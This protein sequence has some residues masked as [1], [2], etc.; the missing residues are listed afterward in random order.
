MFSTFPNL[1]FVIEEVN[2][3]VLN[4]SKQSPTR[5]GLKPRDSI[6]ITEE[7][8]VP[9][10][11]NSQ[12]RLEA[13]KPH[14]PP[15]SSGC[16]RCK[17]LHRMGHA[18]R[19]HRGSSGPQTCPSGVT[20]EHKAQ[21]CVQM[22]LGYLQWETFGCKEL[23]PHALHWWPAQNLIQLL[24]QAA[25]G[26]YLPPVSIFSGAEVVKELG[27]FPLFTCLAWTCL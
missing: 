2:K 3:E 26:G 10:S 16:C 20:P 12:F 18:G 4:H 22:V 19:D 5:L 11:R 13:I 24:S 21:N 1:S 9:A 7:Q 17:A 15:V 25:G 8:W 27:C 6:C 14:W 23:C